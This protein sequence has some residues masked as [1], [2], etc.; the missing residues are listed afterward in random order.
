MKNVKKILSIAMLGVSLFTI[1]PQQTYA[2]SLDDLKLEQMYAGNQSYKD[3]EDNLNADS[4]LT[5]LETPMGTINL[6]Y[7]LTVNDMSFLPMDYDVEVDYGTFSMTKISDSI[8]VS[9]EDKDK[10]IEIL[11]NNMLKVYEEC[12][13]ETPNK[14]IQGSYFNSWY[15]YPHLKVGYKEVRTLSWKN[16]ENNYDINSKAYNG[17]TI[18]G[19]KWNT[20]NDL[21][22][23]GV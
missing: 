12:I 23:F 4:S 15:E 3:L 14:K 7:K 13:K 21:Y 2:L 5:R 16:Y 9:Q 19:F 20:G 18:C 22:K 8:S 17:S 11:K 10:T 6:T 1:S